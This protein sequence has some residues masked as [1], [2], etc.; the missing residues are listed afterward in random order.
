MFEQSNKVFISCGQR[1]DEEKEL[2]QQIQELVR[3][4]TPFEPYFA[5]FQTSLD[6]LSKNIFS[7]LYKCKGFITVMHRRGKVEPGGHS[8]ASVWVEQEIAI[9]AFINEIL[10][11]KFNVI[12]ITQSDIELEGVREQLLLNPTQFTCNDEALDCLRKILPEWAVD[13]G[14]DPSLTLTLRYEK[15]KITP[16]RHDYD[17]IVELTNNSNIKVDEYHVDLNFPK[18]VLPDNKYL[19]EIKDRSSNTHR[20][21]RAPI[22]TQ[23]KTIYPG[24]TI[25]ILRLNYHV[26]EVVF[27]NKAIMNSNVE[28]TLY[29]NDQ[30]LEQVNKSFNEIQEY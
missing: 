4:L 26:D 11:K 28:A 13:L 29:C 7:E 19:H 21:L 23:M 3:E 2:G 25:P 20:F 1:T 18:G 30:M 17:F 10:D 16:E 9:A 8:R 24:D 6:G 12:A 5:E 22:P 15:N 27:K 14:N